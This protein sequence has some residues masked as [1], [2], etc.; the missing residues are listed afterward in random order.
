[1]GGIAGGQT[2]LPKP[3]ATGNINVAEAGNWTNGLPTVTLKQS[4][5]ANSPIVFKAK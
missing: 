4:G 5:T 2:E 1:M 3:G